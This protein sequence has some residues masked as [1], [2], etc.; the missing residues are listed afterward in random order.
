MKQTV[1]ILLILILFLIIPSFVDQLHTCTRAIDGDTIQLEDGS[2]VRYMGIIYLVVPPVYCGEKSTDYSN[3]LVTSAIGGDTIQLEGGSRIRY[4]GVS[5]LSENEAKEVKKIWRVI[6]NQEIVNWDGKEWL[7]KTEVQKK[8]AIKR[9]CEAWRKAKYQRI[10]S[11]EYF[12]EDIDK[13]YRHF[14]QKNSE[15]VMEAKVGLLLSLSAFF[16]GIEVRM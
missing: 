3:I 16:P 11:I 12:I 6:G 7:A 15:G 13:Y 8:E 2:R 1:F 5:T 9:A 10:E 14:E 4:S